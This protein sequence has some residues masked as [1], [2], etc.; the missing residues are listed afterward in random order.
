LT[1]FAHL[2]RNLR[3]RFRL[4]SDVNPE[5]YEKQR[6]KSD[7]GGP[8]RQGRQILPG[9]MRLRAA[10]MDGR[11]RVTTTSSIGNIMNIANTGL[12][13]A[14]VG[15]ST[16]SDNVANSN[17]T[18]YV[19]KVV[20][21]SS[22]VN[23]G[24]GA[25]VTVDGIQRVT[26]S[27]L[28]SASQAATSDSSSASI[29]SSMLD[30]V[31]GMF[32]DPSDTT[33]YFADVNN[34]FSQ[35]A[36]LANDPS[37]SLEK[38]AAIS[39]TQTFLDDSS[40]VASSLSAIQTQADN[41]IQ[42]DVG[43]VN[44]LLTSIA[45]LN[46]DIRA[47]NLSGAD[48][49]GSENIQAQQIAQLA[50]LI[51]IQTTT[52]SD[53]GTVVRTPDG[54]LLADKTAGTVNYNS[55]TT[56]SSYL[57]VTTASGGGQTFD[58]NFS[59]GEISGLM[60]VRNTDIPDALA[61]LNQFV[62]ATVNQINQAHNASS[63]SPAPASLTGKN[64]GLDLP[65]AVG[66]F[67]G[68][69]TV[70]LLDSSGVI[71]HQVAIDFS[72][73]TMSL[74]GGA[75]TSFTPST[76]LSTLNSTLGSNGSATYTN[77]ALTLSATTGGVAIV[78]DPTT[79]SQKAGQGFSQFFG[80]N[81]LIQSSAYSGATGLSSSDP[82]QFPAGQTIGLRLSTDDGSRVRD[83]Q[84]TV[85]AGVTTM[86]GLVNALNATGTGVAPYGSFA[87]DSTGRLTFTSAASP[88]V[89][90]SVTS[91]NTSSTASGASMSQF[92]GLGTANLAA[93]ASSYMINP[94]I[95]QNPALLATAQVNLSAAAG[96]AALSPG[97]NS[98]ATALANADNTV[99]NFSAA[100]DLPAASMTINR[101]AS[102]FAGA[103]ASKAAAADTA[104]TSADAIQT[105]ASSRL[106]SYEGVDMD[107]ELVNLTKYQQAFNAS[108][109][110]VTAAS[111]M[112]DTLLQMVT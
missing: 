11:A 48:A 40:Q 22:L 105:E 16:T 70:A 4:H 80:M 30:Q 49:S 95:N 1:G 102:Q 12:A 99:A 74:D 69:T 50:G 39:S 110:M 55:S 60:Q 112:Y 85:P 78:D 45:Q 44:T 17:T 31:Q 53:G 91:D 34:V 7:P 28:E 100:G 66:G 37:S 90:L 101:Y 35:F 86:G 96:T 68:K 88:A 10:T 5:T 9:P 3:N 72:A 64:T 65:T 32:G 33:G 13:A 26:S 52:S 59:S 2:A 25:G 51:N 79:P 84:F 18:G 82:N 58:A 71:Q 107:E 87:L 75:A 56:A 15:L 62:G 106:S 61:Q 89:N 98:G 92:F 93:N 94:L 54:M 108:A 109:R 77:G 23:Q 97:D 111:Q 24:A 27:Y 38:S 47:A 20:N 21:Q 81:D 14:Q 83:V 67:T 63:A 29:M 76:F 46:G 43:Q 6:F 41:Q 57:T 103:L 8:W 104:Q 36:A 19:R 42:S 73:G